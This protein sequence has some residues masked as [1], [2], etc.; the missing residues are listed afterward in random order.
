MSLRCKTIFFSLEK[1]RD[2]G[3]DLRHRSLRSLFYVTSN[4]WTPCVNQIHTRSTQ[5]DAPPLHP[6]MYSNRG[7]YYSVCDKPN[8]FFFFN[9]TIL[10]GSVV[11]N[12]G[13]FPFT[14][15]TVCAGNRL[16]RWV[17]WLRRTECPCT[18]MR[19]DASDLPVLQV[20]GQLH[21]GLC[22]HHTSY[23]IW[24][25]PILACPSIPLPV[26]NSSPKCLD[27]GAI[28]FF[29]LTLQRSSPT[30]RTQRAPG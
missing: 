7:S 27:T 22:S 26:N 25:E 16:T 24:R 15:Y 19:V 1:N 23:T 10:I 29:P 6:V 18:R 4:R 30:L 20:N 13:C 28:F 14:I 21:S 8:C 9:F 5:D 3:R 17:W 11:E 2:L 12:S